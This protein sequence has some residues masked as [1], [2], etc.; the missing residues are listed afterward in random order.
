MACF[1]V[2]A[3]TFVSAGSQSV[4]EQQTYRMFSVVEQ[5]ALEQNLN[6]N[7][8]AGFRVT[9]MSA[10]AN[11][12]LTVLMRAVAD[13][14]GLFMYRVLYGDWGAKKTRLNFR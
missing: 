10:G 14:S 5:D 4:A 12:N 8:A 1:S 2:V 13:G 11:G 9:A 6:R 7:A 3:L